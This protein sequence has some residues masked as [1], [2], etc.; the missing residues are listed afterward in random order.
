MLEVE[1]ITDSIRNY[2]IQIGLLKQQS[3]INYD[4]IENVQMKIFNLVMQLNYLYEEDYK[5][6]LTQL[7][8]VETIT[9]RDE[10]LK[11]E[12]IVELSQIRE[13]SLDNLF[14]QNVPEEK[15]IYGWLTDVR[16]GL[17]YQ[18]TF[19]EADLQ[20]VNK[21][22]AL[23][24][25]NKNKE[26]LLKEE[27]DNNLLKVK[28]IKKSIM[29]F[30]EF[31]NA[32][33]E[34]YAKYI[35]TNE[36]DK[37]DV[38]AA[39]KSKQR[40]LERQAT[41]TTNM[42]LNKTAKNTDL[43][44]GKLL[45]RIYSNDQIVIEEST[46]L[47]FQKEILDKM[48]LEVHDY[49]SLYQKV[50][51]IANMMS[52]REAELIS[53]HSNIKYPSNLSYRTIYFT[54]DVKLVSDQLYANRNI[55]KLQNRNKEIK[56][57]LETL[58]DNVKGKRELNEII[59]NQK[60]EEID[61]FD[62]APVDQP[63][64]ELDFD[65][66]LG[67]LEAKEPVDSIELKNEVNF[68]LDIPEI[69]PNESLEEIELEQPIEEI[70]PDQLFDKEEPIT[71]LEE[72]PVIDGEILEVEKVEKASSRLLN[73]VRSIKV[74][75]LELSKKSAPFIIAGALLLTPF[76]H[77]LE[78]DYVNEDELLLSPEI[79]ETIEE[80][81]DLEETIS[82]SIGDKVYVD[83]G[84]KYYRDA[85]SAQFDNNGFLVNSSSYGLKAENYNVNRIAI[86]EK[87]MLGNPT[88]KILAVNTSPGVSA[89]ELASSIGLEPE[90]YEVMIHIGEGDD[91]GHYKEAPADAPSDD[92]L[93]WLRANNPLIKVVTPAS[94]I[95][96][97]SGKG[98]TR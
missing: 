51:D 39:I 50:K 49:E 54:N 86:M 29:T 1:T 85:V 65:Q 40:A 74:K 67:E 13:R 30:E 84:T 62:N 22:L 57:E 93:C 34:K 88:G 91:Q 69:K 32:V 31:N 59:T 89:Q 21:Q 47:I 10:Q 5:Q 17:E 72:Q 3:Q 79:T 94:E 80:F 42:E 20:L 58:Y 87:D 63:I 4:E 70:E 96:N 71:E 97:N 95:L 61:N 26:L 52:N 36:I 78:S 14:D 44:M 90:Q 41:I 56:A 23:I 64:S 11:R 77:K 8:S 35:K 25:E 48:N 2:L 12:R 43:T 19:H 45:Y 6:K 68:D 16:R 83:E 7:E 37:I 38:E 81:E 55:E 98:I 24:E 15:E 82:Y 46:E 27:Y 66:A 73:K 33:N 75:L 60:K 53:K 9:I 76:I 28:E 92:D 18:T